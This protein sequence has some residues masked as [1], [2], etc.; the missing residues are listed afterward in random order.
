[1]LRIMAYK[2]LCL[3]VLSLRDHHTCTCAYIHHWSLNRLNGLVWTETHLHLQKVV[4]CTF[5]FSYGVSS[6]WWIRDR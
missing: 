3:W 2:Y 4:A 6:G 1:M 5:A